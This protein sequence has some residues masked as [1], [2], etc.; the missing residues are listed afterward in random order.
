MRG[1]AERQAKLMLGLTPDGFVRKGHPLRRIKPLDDS[2]L[3]RTSPHVRPA[4]RVRRSTLDPT[5]TPDQVEP[6]DGSLHVPLGALFREQLRYNILFK[7]F[8]DMNIEDEP[9]HPTIFMENRK[10][11]LEVDASRMLLKEVVHEA[12]RRS[13]S[14]PLHGSGS[15][16]NIASAPVEPY[17]QP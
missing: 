15:Q 7:W 14:P 13:A 5:R 1:E 16:T 8:L 4:L 9:F 12:R 10:R 17:H 2:V 11:L 6:A 3:R